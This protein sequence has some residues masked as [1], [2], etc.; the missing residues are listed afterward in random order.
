MTKPVESNFTILDYQIEEANFQ[1]KNIVED[2]NTKS[3]LRP[4]VKYSLSIEPDVSIEK[5]DNIFVGEITL[6]V[7]IQGRIAR[8]VKEKIKIKIKGIFIGKNME[9]STF[10]NFCKLNGIANLLMLVRSF[11]ASTTSQMG[12]RAIVIPLVNLYRTLGE[13]KIR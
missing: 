5:E 8:K 3:K 2:L 13:L 4:T 9:H 7:N 11:V 12:R 10:E 1:F 6:T